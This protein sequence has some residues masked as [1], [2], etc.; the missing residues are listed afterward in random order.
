[1]VTFCNIA[2]PHSCNVVA[3]SLVHSLSVTGQIITRNPQRQQTIYRMHNKN[4]E[5]HQ[6]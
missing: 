5:D 3:A 4:K 6:L 1:M 2:L